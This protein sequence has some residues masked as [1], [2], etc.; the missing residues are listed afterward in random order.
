M[1]NP[2]KNI[3]TKN[4]SSQAWIQWHKSL[5]SRYGKKEANAIFIKA[6]DLRGGAGSPASSI[7]LRNYMEDNG[8]KLDTTSMEDALDS[9]SG[10]IDWIGDGLSMGRYFGIALGVIVVGGLGMLIYNIAKQPIKAAGAA[11]NL[12]PASKVGKMLK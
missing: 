7:E 9:A 4:S 11:S 10:A 3:P 2:V 6:W 1:A 8:V 12:I 5:K